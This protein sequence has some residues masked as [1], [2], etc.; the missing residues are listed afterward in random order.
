MGHGDNL[1][2][3]AVNVTTDYRDLDAEE[4]KVCERLAEAL[5][6]QGVK[7]RMPLEGAG[8]RRRLEALTEECWEMA[9]AFVRYSPD[10]AHGVLR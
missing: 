10:G 8:Q 4:Q 7:Y 5:F 6:V 9:F 3:G 1:R 2:G